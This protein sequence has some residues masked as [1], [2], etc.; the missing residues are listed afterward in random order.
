[1]LP[2]IFLNFF[3]NVFV[4]V[5]YVSNGNSFPTPLSEKEEKELFIKYKDGDS[6]AKGELITRNLR[7]VAHIIKKFSPQMRDA[8][9]L[10][11]IGTVGL[12]KA[13]ESFD[14]KK[15]NRL[16]TYAARCIENEILMSVRSSKKTKSEVY[17]QDPIGVDK[18]GN[19]I[20]LIDVLGTD[21]DV[22]LEEVEYK[23]SVKKLYEMI[24]SV[25]EGKEKE[26]IKQRY[27]LSS[28]PKTQ[29][30]IA[31]KLGISRSYVSRIE[32]KALKKLAKELDKG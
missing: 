31:E 5:G 1:M 28:D 29:R 19:E 11:S 21:G 26:I 10:I 25:L 22:V 3:Q 16:A 8:D 15:G 27:G 4:L 12:I 23:I 30:E 6:L 20:C 14:Y 2:D 9:D 17:L 7:L 32:K 18:E 13:I 24:E